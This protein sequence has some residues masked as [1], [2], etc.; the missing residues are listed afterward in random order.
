MKG[1]KIV[2]LA[3]VA[4]FV[5]SAVA[6]TGASAAPE[7]IYKVEQVKLEAG[8]TKEIRSSAKTEFV[9]K[10][11]G[12]LEVESVTKC[13]KIKLNAALH[14]VIVGGTPGTSKNEAIEFEECTATVGGS[15][16]EKVAITS[17]TTNNELVTIVKPTAK[18]GKLATL[19]TP[20]TPPVFSTIKL[21]KCGLFGSREAKVE[22]T[23]AAF[24]TPEAVD[25]VKGTL[26]WNEKEEVTEVEKQGGTKVKVGLTA[27]SKLATLNGE[28]TVELLSGQVWGAF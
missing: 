26:V 17:A 2:G 23:T 15:K 5:M 8:E 10:G 13:K 1:I 11:K 4:I 25:E 12:I 19:F 18:A 22:G 16:C 21:T 7:H 14:P 3:L 6:A 20:A 27:E 9:L 28:A 24:I